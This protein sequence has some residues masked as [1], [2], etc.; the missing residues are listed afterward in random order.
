MN[1]IKTLGVAGVRKLE[2]FIK[3]EDENELWLRDAQPEEEEY[4]FIQKEMEREVYQQH[5]IAE[6]IISKRRTVGESHRVE[7]M[8]KWKGLPY[9]EATWEEESLCVKRFETKIAEYVYRQKNQNCPSA[10]NSYQ[11]RG[12]FKK[13]ESFSCI[14]DGLELRD[15]QMGGVNWLMHAWSKGNSC[16]LAD[17]MGLGKTIQTITFINNLFVNHKRAGPFLCCVPLSTLAAW[18]H[19]FQKWAPQINTI[20]YIGDQQSRNMIYEYEW[21]TRKELKFNVILTTYEIALREADL[22]NKVRWAVLA[23]DEAH[24]LKNDEAQLYRVLNDLKT[25]HR[26]LITGE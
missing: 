7:Y 23:V 8:I 12:K 9:S 25:E 24:R 17:E 18:Q 16:I 6:R 4:H 13:Q 19:E 26:L 14:P 1:S 22:F 21:G 15:Y 5:V 10:N 20:A 2:N 11:K 3:R